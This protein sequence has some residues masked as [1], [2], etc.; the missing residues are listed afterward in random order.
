MQLEF[1]TKSKKTSSL[2][3]KSPKS[4]KSNLV[5]TKS[6]PS[7]GRDFDFW[8]RSSIS[9][10]YAYLNAKLTKIRKSRRS[11]ST[12]WYKPGD[13]QLYS[14]YLVCK[15]AQALNKNERDVLALAKRLK[16]EL[17][18]SVFSDNH[19][20]A[21]LFYNLLKEIGYVGW[22]DTVMRL[23]N[24]LKIPMS[25]LRRFYHFVRYR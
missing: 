18:Q 25:F 9:Y 21:D 15:K 8:I 16:Y 11:M 3:F 4:G 12:G 13:R 6:L 14:T 5:Y 7:S 1:W 24:H 20:E 2:N 17:R 19:R 23:L 10:K 22:A